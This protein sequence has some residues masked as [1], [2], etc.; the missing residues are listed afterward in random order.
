MNCEKL[1]CYSETLELTE[2]NQKWVR[3]IRTFSI[4]GVFYEFSLIE[5]NSVLLHLNDIY[6]SKKHRNIEK[7]RLSLVRFDI[8]GKF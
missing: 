3:G 8:P 4:F 1:V 7:I 6:E 5:P 2:P